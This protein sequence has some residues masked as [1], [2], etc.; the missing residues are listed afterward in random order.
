M[1]SDWD[2]EMAPGIGDEAAG[3]AGGALSGIHGGRETIAPHGGA[4]VDLRVTDSDAER[5]AAE[6]RNLPS[7]LLTARE[8]SDLEMLTIG[9]FSPLRGFMTTADYESVLAGMRLADGTLWSLPITLSM[10]REEGLAAQRAGRTA[11]Y[12]GDGSLLAVMDVEDVYDYDK[13]REARLAYGTADDRHPGVAAVYR[14]EERLVG[15]RLHVVRQPAHEDFLAYRHEPA[16]TRRCFV[17]NG[18]RTV[19]GFQTRNPVHRAHEYIQKCA[20]EIVDALF[21]HPIVG[22]TKGDDIPADVR[23]RCYE[24]LLERYYPKDRTMLCVN[25]ANMRYAGPK[26]AVF[27]AI[28]RRNYGCTH[29]IV[30]RDHAGVGDYYGPFDAHRIFD[31]IPPA[32]L[33]IVPLFFDH[34]FYCRRCGNMASTKTCPHPGEDRLHLSGTRVREMLRDGETPPAQFTRPEVAEVL[35]E[36]MRG[37]AFGG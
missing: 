3:V 17:A 24:V 30:G 9:A 26:E 22:A 11:L 14:Q 29:F 32:D 6:A 13:E 31:D 1:V 23:M 7:R 34:T 10:S 36:A 27:H 15:G 18:W 12:H 8:L 19:V 4:L 33:G 20:L 37:R 16:E 28:V 21:L 25:P 5:L 2:R 35:I